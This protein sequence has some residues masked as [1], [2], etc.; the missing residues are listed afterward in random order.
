MIGSDPPQSFDSVTAL[1]GADHDRLDA[2]DRFW[3]RDTRVR[4]AILDHADRFEL[5]REFAHHLMPA[6]RHEQGAGGVPPR[7]HSLVDPAE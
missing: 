2:I 6:V 4:R 7:H 5:L 3:M 1:L